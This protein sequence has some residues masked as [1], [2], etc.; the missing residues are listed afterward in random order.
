MKGNKFQVYTKKGCKFC[1]LAKQL[2]DEYNIAYELIDIL[3]KPLEN[4]LLESIDSE[5]S[6]NSTSEVILERLYKAKAQGVPQIYAQ[7]HHIGGY[8]ELKQLQSNGTLFTDLL[9]DA[10]ISFTEVIKGPK[11][12]HLKHH[13]SENVAIV[14]EIAFLAQSRKLP[15][16]NSTQLRTIL[17]GTYSTT[18]QI[19]ASDIAILRL[20]HEIQ[21]TFLNLVDNYTIVDDTEKTAFLDYPALATSSEFISY[22]GLSTFLSDISPNQIISL[23][24]EEKQ[25]FFANLYNALV[26]HAKVLF[27]LTSPD[28]QSNTLE[29]QTQ[30]SMEERG[31]FFTG[32]GGAIYQIAGQLLS[33]DDIEHGILRANRPHPSKRSQ[34]STYFEGYTTS[35]LL[36]SP[37]ISEEDLTTLSQF[38]ISDCS[39]DPRIHFILNC[40]AKS[41]PAITVLHPANLEESF[42]TASRSY[43]RSEISIDNESKRIHLPKLLLWYA[44]DFGESL[45]KRLQRWLSYMRLPTASTL[46]PHKDSSLISDQL[47]AILSN[48]EE[49][50]K[51][52][53]EVV[54]TDYNWDLNSYR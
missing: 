34:Q 44:D 26:I 9:R 22:L 43:L 6:P 32:E 16:I 54:Y 11:G 51:S 31:K 21:E 2:L 28:L 8:E 5:Q 42:A 30:T 18:I 24:S 39:F 47:E 46:V 41:C 13:P 1:I 29:F 19:E 36:P 12:T 3:D 10:R 14:K 37:S 33:L 23:S 17:S 40:G 49:F 38:S 45:Y 52:R 4:A 15:C 48:E 27:S 50:S 53:Y 35:K 20:S 7:H 25:C